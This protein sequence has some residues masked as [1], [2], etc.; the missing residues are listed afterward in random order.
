MLPKSPTQYRNRK[1]TLL[2][3]RVYVIIYV[4]AFLNILESMVTHNK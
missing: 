2:L 1:L 4:Y 3:Y